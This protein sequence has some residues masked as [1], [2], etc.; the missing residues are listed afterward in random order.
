MRIAC[1]ETRDALAMSIAKSTLSQTQWA[2]L[3]GIKA[4]TIS[5]I[6]YENSISAQRENK[7]R[8]AVGLDEI[9]F[10]YA[11]VRFEIGREQVVVRRVPRGPRGVFT[12]QIRCTPEERDLIDAVVARAGCR[13]FNEWFRKF[14]LAEVIALHAYESPH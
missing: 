5:D 8:R 10:D 9:K 14:W 1:K 11:T 6:L 12:R 13:S 4:S 2:N 3:N 7:V